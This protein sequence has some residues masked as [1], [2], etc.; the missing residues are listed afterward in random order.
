MPR[1]IGSFVKLLFGTSTHDVDIEGN[2]DHEP[3][4]SSSPL[5]QHA[6]PSVAQQDASLTT[7]WQLH[8]VDPLTQSNF[9][10]FYKPKSLPYSFIF[11]AAV[12]CLILV[13]LS[14]YGLATAHASR[15]DRLISLVF[16]TIVAFLL[17][18]LVAICCL[19]RLKYSP[20]LGLSDHVSESMKAKT[21]F[22][23]M[24][25]PF[26]TTAV[27]EPRSAR[28]SQSSATV[29]S[30][31]T[32][33]IHNVKA[34]ACCSLDFKALGLFEGN[35]LEHAL[36]QILQLLLMLSILQIMMLF[37]SQQSMT[38][39]SANIHFLQDSRAHFIASSGLLLFALPYC[40]FTI[41]GSSIAITWIWIL[42]GISAMFMIILCI[43]SEAYSMILAISLIVGW[44]VCLSIDM[45]L[46]R[47]RI[48]M[49]NR[50]LLQSLNDRASTNAQEM[51]HMIANVAHD[52]K[53][54]SHSLVNSV[55][56]LWC[57]NLSSRFFYCCA[58][59]DFILNWP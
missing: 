45:Q 13:P 29:R 14:L 32:T 27:E 48:F 57:T 31:V 10:T 39:L 8:F 12:V 44:F 49:V 52:L 15:K 20:D 56:S 19:L 51:R 5:Q 54:V 28:S 1:R 46:H 33:V 3:S 23:S 30:M 41:L 21:A 11:A 38:S 58:A 6:A 2:G 16:D 55:C 59:S 25:T 43:V 22:Q 4:R 35:R 37:H 7:T 53:T 18:A 47:L 17:L 42:Y 24:A 26:P 9:E 50:Q 34:T 36:L 40:V